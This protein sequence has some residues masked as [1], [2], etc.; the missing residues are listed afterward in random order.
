MTDSFSKIS[1]FIMSTQ[2]FLDY[3]W[4]RIAFVSIV[5]FPPTAEHC[6]LGLIPQDVPVYMDIISSG[7]HTAPE[8]A[9]A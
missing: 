2:L 1:S 7:F 4:F 3:K 9:T 8:E 6:N 5:I